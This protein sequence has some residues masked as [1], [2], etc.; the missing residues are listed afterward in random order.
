MEQHPIPQQISSYQFRLVGDMTLKQFT[1]L[2]GGC[3]VAFLVYATPLPP[4]V[5][6]PIIILAVAF[7]GALAFLP[8]QERPL[9]KWMAAFF[10]SIYTPTMFYWDK[11]PTSVAFFQNEP[12]PAADQQIPAVPVA[13]V[14]SQ[15]NNSKSNVSSKFEKE[16][17]AFLSKIGEMM[18]SIQNSAVSS[19]VNVLPSS[20]VSP[21]NPAGASIEIP[22]TPLITVLRTN[23]PIQNPKETKSVQPQTFVK[24][25]SI[26]ATTSQKVEGVSPVFTQNAAPPTPP[27]N[28]NIVVGQALDSS[29]KIIEGVI[30]E[31]RDVSGRP[32]RAL[33]TNKLGHFMIVTPL[34]NGKY[35]MVA[36]K[37]GFTFATVTIDANGDIIQPVLV[38]AKP[39]NS[40]N[41]KFEYRNSKQ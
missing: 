11:L 26:A 1:E 24:P 35:E 32:V 15:I 14:Q 21:K 10:R 28:P 38:Q 4:I 36:E 27:T 18:S 7:G 5:K 16:E 12:A 2:G 34:M 23:T 41:P 8:F 3:L 39:I 22:K 31:I 17:S 30:M 33:R 37:E 19:T 20:N 25:A 6:W 13:A 9:E 29:G 40:E